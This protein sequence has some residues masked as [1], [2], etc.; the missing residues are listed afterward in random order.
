M[1][2]R[3]WQVIEGGVVARKVVN[4]ATLDNAAKRWLDKGC[5][6]PTLALQT[7]ATQD[8]IAKRGVVIAEERAYVNGLRAGR[9]GVAA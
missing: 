3:S 2:T 4:A 1:K 7:G 9:F 5:A 8:R 6:L